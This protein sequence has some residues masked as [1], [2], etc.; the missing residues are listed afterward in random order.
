[1]IRNL[2]EWPFEQFSKPLII[3]FLL[4]YYIT[5]NTE[6][7][8]IFWL[9]I[10]A[11]LCS[12]SGDVLL[13]YQEMNSLYFMLGLG[14][15]LLAHIFY[16]S[17]NI[18]TK[19]SEA[20][21]PLLPTQKLRHS[22]TLILVGVALISILSPSL[23]DLRLPVTIYTAII[24]FMAITALLRYGYTPIKSFG[25]IFGGA[26][27]FM[28]SDSLLAINKFLEPIGFAGFWIMATYCLAQYLLIEGIITHQK[29]NKK[30]AV[31]R[32][33]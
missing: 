26:L 10:L 29:N 4:L 14:S 13:M 22:I 28:I 17:V 18:K 8:A 30:E 16:S 5:S 19:W 1:M 25:L 15:F 7:T 3:I 21:N 20:D 2:L 11:L 32:R 33:S 9:T 24:V 31:S 6:R 23:G 27:T 12:W